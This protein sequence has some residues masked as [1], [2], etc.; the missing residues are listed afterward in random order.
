MKRAETQ[1]MARLLGAR[2][3]GSISRRTDI[4]VVGMNPGPAKLEHAR[5]LGV[6]VISEDDWY[7]RISISS[8]SSISMPRGDNG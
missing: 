4:V 1:E 3:T 8:I 5:Q 6:E 2:V 7:R